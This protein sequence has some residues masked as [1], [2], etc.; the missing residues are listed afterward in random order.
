MHKQDE[1][2]MGTWQRA[3]YLRNPLFT[4][5]LPV[6]NRETE[7]ARFVSLTFTFATHRTVKFKVIGPK[8]TKC[9]GSLGTSISVFLTTELSL[10]RVPELGSVSVTSLESTM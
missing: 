3:W 5:A 4:V 2:V 10:E 9:L 7:P 8:V 1:Q 6:L